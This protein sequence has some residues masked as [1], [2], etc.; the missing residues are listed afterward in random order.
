MDNL[1]FSRT[2]SVKLNMCYEDI[3]FE[4]Q[5]TEFLQFL[6]DKDQVPLNFL[7]N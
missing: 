6:L 5:G 2:K 3:A 7:D 1:T 4:T